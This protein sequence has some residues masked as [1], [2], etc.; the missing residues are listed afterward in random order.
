MKLPAYLAPVLA[1]ALAAAAVAQPAAAFTR[2][3][4]DLSV[5]KSFGSDGTPND[6]GMSAALSPL[7]NAGDRSRF[8]VTAFA[9]DIGTS[10]TVLFDRT[11]SVDLGTIAQRHRMSYGLAWRG[12]RDVIRRPR[13]A[14]GLT[15]LAGWW[16]VA[17]DVRGNG[18]EA[19]SAVGYALGLDARRRM[20]P[21][22]E[23]GL[24][25]RYQELTS[26]RHSVFRRVDHY[27]TAAL[28]W[29][30]TVDAGK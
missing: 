29:R 15:A 5:G 1:A 28:E 16:R 6:G 30:W 23:V 7:W 4:I 3:I 9:D 14:A 22:H 21:R 11:G 8:G 17:D 26:D 10:R 27:G 19:V 13:W 24:A 12:D 18:A 2:P 20:S 25:V